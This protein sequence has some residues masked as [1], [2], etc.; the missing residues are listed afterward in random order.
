[1]RW[2]IPVR[3]QINADD[4]MS[5]ASV[6]QLRREHDDLDHFV[7]ALSHD[8]NANFMLL[9]NS[10]TRLKES[11][12]SPL[13]PDLGQLVDHV[14][15]CLR[16]SRKFLDDMVLLGRTGSVR[17]EPDR[18]E[19]AEVVREVLFEQREIIS[20]ANARVV[21]DEPLPVVWCN[22]QRVKQIVGNL[23]RN[24]VKHG[25]DPHRPQITISAVRRTPVEGEAAERPTGSIRIHD[26]G[27]GIDPRFR[28]EIFLPGR[29]LPGSNPEGSGMGL[30]IVKRIVEH[31]EGSVE[32]DPE[33]K[34]GTAVVVTLPVAAEPRS[35]EVTQRQQ[36][37]DTNDRREGIG[38]DGPHGEHTSP[39]HRPF[40]RRRKRHGRS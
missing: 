35:A 33:C 38:H 23:V 26:N 6:Q 18:V 31:Y 1:M 39:P 36:A 37:A 5:T 13:R 3:L 11:L 17:M 21:V 14:E 4:V 28:E 20:A 8:M 7:R 16:E 12:D 9:D 29:R 19:V 27:P 32:V 15:A 25:C 40:S 30:A 34:A 24:A 2:M 10:F 22:R